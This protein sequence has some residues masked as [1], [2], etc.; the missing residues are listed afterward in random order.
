[1]SNLTIQLD[2]VAL[3]E[4]TTQAIMGLLTPE[5]RAEILQ[6]AICELLQPSTNSWEKGV[7]PLQRAFNSAVELIAR[8]LARENIKADKNIT[9]KMEALLEETKS[10]VLNLDTDKLA[11]KMADAFVSSIERNR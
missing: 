2:P 8:E 10:K 4:A 9:E 7:S 11:E 3:R 5:I 1:M 6:K